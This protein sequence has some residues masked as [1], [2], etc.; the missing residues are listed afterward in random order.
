MP[1]S[2]L[3]Q[4]IP[5]L[6]RTVFRSEPVAFA[7]LFG[8]YAGGHPDEESDERDRSERILY[9]WKIRRRFDDEQYQRTRREEYT[10]RRILSS[11]P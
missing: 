11:V 8:S 2:D 1:K 6:L 4:R 7:Y 3:Q 10:L 9:E 5:G